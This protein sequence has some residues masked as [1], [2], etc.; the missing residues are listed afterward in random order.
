MALT[1]FD[2]E[3]LEGWAASNCLQKDGQKV[4]CLQQDGRWSVS[5]DKLSELLGWSWIG[6]VLERCTAKRIL[7]CYSRTGEW[8]CSGTET[9]AGSQSAPFGGRGAL[10]GMGW[11]RCCREIWRSWKYCQHQW[12]SN[13]FLLI[14]DK[15]T[16]S[17]Y[18]LSSFPASNGTGKVKQFLS[19]FIY[20]PTLW[21]LRGRQFVSH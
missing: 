10:V 6:W 11:V 14:L 12:I 19:Y 18:I 3:H 5:R 21:L 8:F 1:G 7:V 16:H 20:H 2:A 17:I 15:H 13:P 4:L 9:T